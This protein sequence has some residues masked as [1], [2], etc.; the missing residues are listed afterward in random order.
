[1]LIL[2]F[3]PGLN[4]RIGENDEV[5][6]ETDEVV[7]VMTSDWASSLINSFRSGKFMSLNKR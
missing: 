7:A 6:E 2:Y 1:M 3:S 5:D 4:E